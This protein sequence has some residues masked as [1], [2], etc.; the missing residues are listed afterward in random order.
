MQTLL[1][2]RRLQPFDVPEGSWV[3][4]I[5]ETVFQTYP[6]ALLGCCLQALRGSDARLFGACRAFLERLARAPEGEDHLSLPAVSLAAQVLTPLPDVQQWLRQSVHAFRKGAC[7]VLPNQCCFRPVQSTL[8]SVRCAGS[9]HSV[10]RGC[11]S[12]AVERKRSAR[13]SAAPA[14]AAARCSGHARGSTDGQAASEKTATRGYT[15]RGWGTHW[16][17]RGWGQAVGA[18]G[19]HCCWVGVLDMTSVYYSWRS[20]ACK[21]I[22]ASWSMCMPGVVATRC[23][24]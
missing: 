7:P 6:Q 16:R 13:A 23:I 21:P 10:H 20:G 19:R 22:D 3:W 11:R 14:A 4:R 8:L 15:S 12:F 17:T 9:I 18:V 24:I 2:S 1:L 5:L